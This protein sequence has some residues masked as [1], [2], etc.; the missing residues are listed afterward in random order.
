M[1]GGISNFNPG[2]N[3]KQSISGSC[4][5]RVFC[6]ITGFNSW[7][8]ALV[9]SVLLIGSVI[10]IYRQ[11][12]TIRNFKRSNLQQEVI[13]VV[14]R[15]IQDVPEFRMAQGAQ[16]D[17]EFSNSYPMDQPENREVPEASFPRFPLTPPNK[18]NPTDWLAYLDAAALSHLEDNSF[19]LDVLCET[20]GISRRQFQRR[21]KAIAG[22]TATEYLN[23]LRLQRALQLLQ[24]GQVKTVKSLAAAVGMRDVKYFSQAFKKRFGVLPSSFLSTKV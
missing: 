10:I 19:T 1:P 5:C 9:F 18:L 2:R 3:V 11:Q 20:M 16:H 7:E 12:R 15:S 24:E 6:F 14:R 22:L 23:E 13:P 8:L 17:P 4:Y 21:L